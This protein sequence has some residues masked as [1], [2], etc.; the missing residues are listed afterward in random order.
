MDINKKVRIFSLAVTAFALLAIFASSSNNS[1]HPEE[2][3]AIAAGDLPQQIHPVD[4]DRKFD[5]AGEVVPM[6]NFDARE[7]LDRELLVNSYWQSSTLLNIKRTTRYFPI[8]EK[9]LAKNGVPEDFKYLA[10]AESDLMNGTS[11]AGAKGIWQFMENTGEYYDLEI[12]KEVD[13]RF[14]VEKATEAACQYIL[15]YKK[16]F[17]TWTMAAAAYNLGGT[18]LASEIKEQQAETYYDLNLNSETSRYVFRVLA[19]KEILNR[20]Q[21]FGYRLEPKDMYPPLDNY[22]IV[23]VDGPIDDLAAFAKEHKVSYRHLKVYNPWLRT[24]KLSNPKGKTYEIKIPK[25][26][27]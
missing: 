24:S 19:L 3:R 11:Y 8:I 9:I 13:E 20:P 12:N 15:G 26:K 7:R 1:D 6:D 10:V 21:D 27:L 23:K 4:L 5:L 18:K 2:T 17:G 22:E 14:H 25:K 16:R